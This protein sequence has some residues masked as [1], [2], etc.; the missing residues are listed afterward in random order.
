MLKQPTSLPAM[1]YMLMLRAL[2]GSPVTS[3]PFPLAVT[4]NEA[5]LSTMFSTASVPDPKVDTVQP[6]SVAMEVALMP[7]SGTSFS[8]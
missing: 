2:L 6:F 4:V 7:A 1:S 8:R 3:Q 5:F